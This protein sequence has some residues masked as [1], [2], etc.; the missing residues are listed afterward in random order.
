MTPLVS[1]LIVTHRRRNLALRCIESCLNQDYPQIQIVVVLNP[2]DPDLETEIKKKSEKIKIIRTHRNIGFFPALNLAIANCDGQYTMTVDDD[3]YFI[4]NDVISKL[5]LEFNKDSNLGAV[6]CN[7]LGHK[8]KTFEGSDRYVHV[9]KTGFT[10]I[11]KSAF[12]EW[13]GYYPDLFFRSA[14][15]TYLC[16]ALWDQGRKVKCL[17]DAKMYHD[18]STE[19]RSDFDWKFYGMRSQNLCVIMREPWFLILPSLASKF[20]KSFI[21]FI[22]WKAFPVWIKTW[23]STFVFIPDAIALRKPI[24]WKT[25]KVLKKMQKENGI[26]TDSI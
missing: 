5:I 8:E 7:I 23:W 19:G 4:S 21:N 2:F 20:I 26:P 3:A 24:S 25:Y 11:P 9:F 16:M 12:T 6:T 22:K 18:L 1:I 15:E 10:M 13:V 14:G 17:T